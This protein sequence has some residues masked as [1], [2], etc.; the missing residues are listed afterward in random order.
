MKTAEIQK[1]I[2]K[3]EVLK[4]NLACENVDYLL[5]WECDVLSLNKTGYLSEFEVKVS[6]SDFLA[7]KKKVRKWQLLIERNEWACPNYF[8][9][10]CPEGLISETEV[11]EYAG[12]IY[13]S[14]EGLE[15]YKSAKLLHKGKKD[16]DKVLTKFCRITTERIYLGGCRMTYENR[17]SKE[18]YNIE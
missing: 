16:L 3:T 8:W 2:C 7:E 14:T 9:Y 18:H 1:L 4:R 12:L 6:R 13:V 11:P 15:I 5:A 10:V 17:R